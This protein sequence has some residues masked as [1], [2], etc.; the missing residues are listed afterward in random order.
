MITITLFRW[1]DIDKMTKISCWH[2]FL[3]GSSLTYLEEVTTIGHLRDVSSGCN[4][5]LAQKI[6]DI[7]NIQTKSSFILGKMMIDI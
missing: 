1:S 5:N 2:S 6:F 7:F 4:R 3:R